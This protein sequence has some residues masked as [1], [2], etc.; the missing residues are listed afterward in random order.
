MDNLRPSTEPASGRKLEVN[1]D[2]T[3]IGG[4]L[5]GKASSLQL[6]RAGLSVICL[7][8]EESVRQPVGESLDW[9]AP[10]LLLSLIHI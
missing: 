5:A 7:E 2:V 9:S 8:P 1:C 3:V 10:E 6:A 4:G